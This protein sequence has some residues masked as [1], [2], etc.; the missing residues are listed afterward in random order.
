MLNAVPD[1]INSYRNIYNEYGILSG[2]SEE[3]EI[4]SE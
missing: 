4:N 3:R 1:R 2:D